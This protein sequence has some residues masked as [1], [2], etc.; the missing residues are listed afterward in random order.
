MSPSH[1]KSV[2]PAGG[3]IAFFVISI[4]LLSG[5]GFAQTTGTVSGVIT[6]EGSGEPLPGANVVLKGTRRGAASDVDGSYTILG[7]APGTYTLVAQLLG[8]KDRE[9]EVRVGANEKT[10]VNFQLEASAIQ[11][12][13]I[14]VTG[15]GTELKKREVTTPVA[16]IS[17]PEIRSAPAA[18]IAE[19]I[20]G[21]VA[22]VKVN[23][24]TGLPGTGARLRTRGVTSANVSQTPILYI[25]GVRVDA[26]DN[27]RLGN[28]VTA[29]GGPASSALSD[30]LVDEIERIEVTKGGAA[31]TLFGSEAAGG[32]IQIFTKKGRPG[33]AQWTARTEQGF[34]SPS[35]Q[36]V[37]TNF[38][39][40]EVLRTGYVQ[41]YSVGV[42]GGSDFITYN[43]GFRVKNE[44]FTLPTVDNT[45]YLM[46]GGLRAFLSDK[47]QIDV[48]FGA[49]RDQFG[50]FFSDNAIASLLSGVESNS[51]GIP[52]DDETLANDPAALQQARQLLNDALV[53]DLNEAVNRYT[54]GTTLSYDPYSIFSNRLTLGLDYRKNE[55][56]QFVPVASNPVIFG[57]Q[58]AG[59]LDRSDRENL[60]VTLDYAGT[61]SYPNK[62]IFTS[63]F[64]FGAQGF[65]EED[66]ESAVSATELGLPGTDD[67]DN[68]AEVIAFEDNRQLFNGG[69]F[70]SEQIGLWNRLFVNLGV[71]FDG[72]SAFGD[73]VGLQ[74]YPKAGLAYNL[75]EQSF[76][77]KSFLASFWDDLKLRASFGRTG[78]FP[79]PFV[80]DRTFTQG[81]F[82][83]QVSVGFNN[84]G[85][86]NLGPE[87]T[88]TFDVG[89][90]AAL[91]K[92][93]IGVEF[94]Y[95]TA[96]TKDALFTVPNQT[97]T[98][99]GA[100]LRNVG[101]IENRGI[102]LGLN[103]TIL[104]Q[105][106]FRWTGGLTFTTLDNEVKSLG[107]S[108]PFTIGGFAFLPLRVEEGKPVGVFLTNVPQADGTFETV[109][110]KGALPTKSGSVFTTVQLFRKLSLSTLAD[111]Q[112]GGYILN[113]GAV[114][115]FFNGLEPHASLVPDGFTFSTASEAFIDDSDYFKLREISARYE[116]GNLGVGQ[117]LRNLAVTASVR[118]VY[119]W[120]RLRFDD[121]DPE[122]SGVRSAGTGLD[123]GGI[124]FFTLSPPRTFRF[125]LE[126]GI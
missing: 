59:S 60:T 114:L 30:I 10:A 122:L 2:I 98:G 4:L 17:A 12:D 105:R 35:D 83:N 118:N 79:D 42:N 51:F 16:T 70:F 71:R 80:K 1:F 64:T 31:S 100:Q 5:T 63:T 93:R 107:G 74:T 32:V 58:A 3:M 29:T 53:A 39:K 69:F 88:E 8:Y 78:K 43:L 106:D 57:G 92:N 119:T 84:A 25:D 96:T 67:F 99:F 97:S 19:L 77:K 54:L 38:F 120:H 104:N 101:E 61:I 68:A 45:T 18:N 50:R 116:F 113:T 117:W 91:L 23:L 124:N 65:R 87:T 37:L 94:S 55:N 15:T 123:V 47:T 112:T 126:V 52:F 34:N 41:N 28:V 75:S 90:D 103:A 22:G 14:V 121:L 56:R 111:W 108:Q 44:E 76:W 46:R 102:E 82:L 26:D 7:V 110:E 27:F 66:R 33:P 13:A 86:E 20:N 81:S 85:D 125:G 6:A 115:R 40:N 11:L 62:G 48:S 95:F 89:F 109:L 72:N 21:R 9:V 49:T 36:F 24:N 73:E